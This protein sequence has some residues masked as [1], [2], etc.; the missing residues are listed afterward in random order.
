MNGA[1]R[2]TGRN[3]GVNRFIID[4][5]VFSSVNTNGGGDINKSTRSIPLDYEKII[6]KLEGDIRNHIRI[7]QQL[8]LH[9]ESVQS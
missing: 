3:T 8:K 4:T 2:R 9:I 6:Q 5:S 1:E 7:E